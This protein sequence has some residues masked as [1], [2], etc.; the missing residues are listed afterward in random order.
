MPLAAPESTVVTIQ[1]MSS[2]AQ[3]NAGKTCTCSHQ[4]A[5]PILKTFEE[6][7]LQIMK[8]QKEAPAVKTVKKD[9][10]NYNF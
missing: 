1:S 2:S 3:E 5:S 9:C 4:K 8:A 7:L 10:W 6:I